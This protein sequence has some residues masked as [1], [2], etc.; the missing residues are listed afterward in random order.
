MNKNSL[1]VIAN[2]IVALGLFALIAY[3]K[4]DWTQCA[5][6]IVLL[7]I[8][9]ALGIKRGD[10]SGSTRPPPP[11]PPAA[12]VLL[13]LGLAGALEYVVSGPVPEPIVDS[14]MVATEMT[15]GCAFL[16]SDTGKAITSLGIDMVQCLIAH[17]DLDTDKALLTCGVSAAQAELA[18]LVLGDARKASAQA[19]MNA[20]LDE[21]AKLASQGDA[22]C[23][24]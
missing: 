13:L 24:R 18:K 8:P 1:I 14:A 9:S 15:T 4:I 21:R 3:G 2:V 10:S 19:A 6:G 11:P 17:Q 22:G 16:K 5:A 20:R 12:T 7:G 23:P